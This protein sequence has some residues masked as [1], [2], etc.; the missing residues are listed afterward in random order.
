[1]RRVC[2]A[3]AFLVSIAIPLWSQVETSKLKIR[4]ILMDKDLNQ[5]P[6]P[7]LTVVLS[8]DSDGKDA[9]QEVKTDFDGNAEIV[10]SLANTN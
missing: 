6:V 4:A 1:M 10:L 7:H 9:S 2:I 3:V 8:A 5:K